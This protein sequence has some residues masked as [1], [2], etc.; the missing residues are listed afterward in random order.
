M[1]FIFVILLVSGLAL[2][3][4]QGL[5]NPQL[6][7]VVAGD[8]TLRE[9][10]TTLT[11]TQTTDR[12]ILN[13]NSFD[14]GAGEKTDFVQLDSDS[15]VL[16]R[17]L[18]PG[19]STI[20]GELTAVGRVF[21]VNPE[22]VVFTSDAN[23][24]L[25]G[26]LVSAADI[27]DQ[28]FLDDRL[29]F[30]QPGMPGSMITNHGDISTQGNAVLLADRIVNHGLIQARL[31]SVS[32]G[33]VATATI[34]FA[35]DGLLSL[36]TQ[37]TSALVKNESDGR[38]EALGGNVYISALAED[39]ILDE[40][41]NLDGV[42]QATHAA[43]EGGTI[44][45]YGGTRGTVLVSGEV[46]ATGE[47][48]TVS[49]D[50]QRIGLLAGGSVKAPGGQ[51]EVGLGTPASAD[52]SERIFLAS[53]AALDVAPAD[54]GEDA[55]TV[56]LQAT[57]GAQLQGSV[58]ANGRA[59]GSGG[60]LDLSAGQFELSGDV[61]V[62][63]AT[64]G[65]LILRGSQVLVANSAIAA[66]PMFADIPTSVV[67][68]AQ[69]SGLNSSVTLDGTGSLVL[70][71]GVN[72]DFVNL[73]GS[74][75]VVLRGAQM[76]L[77]PGFAVRTYG[78]ALTLEAYG[79]ADPN[80]WGELD[81]V[82]SGSIITGG[83][84]VV[85]ESDILQPALSDFDVGGGAVT[86]RGTEVNIAQIGE[87]DALAGVVTIT[88]VVSANIERVFA[89]EL[90]IS[91]GVSATVGG[92][93]PRVVGVALFAAP[94]Q[95][96]PALLGKLNVQAPDVDLLLGVF[97][98]S[99]S[100][101]I[102]ADAL[103]MAPGIRFSGGDLSIE[104][105]R[106]AP[107]LIVLTQGTGVVAPES[108]LLEPFS[109]LVISS[110]ILQIENRFRSITIGRDNGADNIF[111]SN[112]DLT[113]SVALDVPLT[114]KA[115]NGLIGI[116]G[117]VL[118]ESALTTQGKV[119]LSGSIVTQG[120]PL[121]FDDV[122]RVSDDLVIDTTFGA[123]IGGAD[124]TFTD[125]VV[126][127]DATTAPN[128]TIFGTTQTNVRIDDIT[129]FADLTI[130]GVGT[131]DI[132]GSVTAQILNL[133]IADRF[134][135]DGALNLSGGLINGAG[136]TIALQSGGNLGFINLNAAPLELGGDLTVFG[137]F[138]ANDL[139]LTSPATIT[140]IPGPAGGAAISIAGTVTSQGNALTL[141]T[142]GVGSIDA[143]SLTNDFAQLNFNA[144]G[145]TIGAAAADGFTGV[146]SGA[147]D[148]AVGGDLFASLDVAGTTTL[149]STGRVLL[150]GTGNSFADTISIQAA[151]GV[152]LTAPTLLL[153]AS[154]FGAGD[155]DIVTGGLEILGPLS[156]SGQ[157]SFRPSDPTQTV[158]LG[159]ESGLTGFGL[160]DAEMANISD[161]FAGITFIGPSLITVTDATFRDPVTFQEG[162]PA[163]QLQIVGDLVGLDDASFTI[164]GT[165]QT[166]FLAGNIFTQGRPIVFNDSVVLLS[167]VLLDT[168]AGPG[169]AAGD[170]TMNLGLQG[171]GFAL[172][173]A[174][175]RWVNNPNFPLDVGR[176]NVDSTAASNSSALV[177]GVVAGAGA[178]GAAPLVSLSGFAPDAGFLIN[179]CAMA[180][181]C[182]GGYIRGLVNLPPPVIQISR[183]TQEATTVLRDGASRLVD[184]LDTRHSNFG[185]ERLWWEQPERFLATEEER[186]D[187]D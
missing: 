59:D 31:G 45:L 99:E 187:E 140:T 41:V 49:I 104:P 79:T 108:F 53:G 172:S 92:Q 181:A 130:E 183:A 15:V 133:D 67:T 153:G 39:A 141:E 114:L 17:V 56:S 44:R 90:N 40:V 164:N 32:L 18:G 100:I 136:A 46:A 6:D 150:G 27:D 125:L 144:A 16:N 13:W 9:S 38:I 126:D 63:G 143:P 118:S 73:P 185:N 147:L 26:L 77:E 61:D 146:V 131:V 57:A 121:V 186:P 37:T 33:G 95:F 171:G 156:G 14:I 43:E 180:I 93:V 105:Y 154:D 70:E 80:D 112:G 103:D 74:G 10:G 54:G 72:L 119:L 161:G 35:G 109:P 48:V 68:G 36:A 24:N 134:A 137:D 124:V 81:F 158:E 148:L 69:L 98:V 28:D 122:V 82:E 7:S 58:S 149:S 178:R 87:P 78:S 182:E 138:T 22:G 94:G 11:V 66:L 86:A 169:L 84:D 174:A 19:I 167:D 117:L 88:G 135:V 132:A 113:E 163:S 168:R 162:S 62:G 116:D 1:R 8:V 166:T 12:A 42:V 96:Y 155:V 76:R 102:K 51:V 89:Q 160:S 71:S 91:A 139:L 123:N 142:G 145:V 115:P 97:D 55:G 83:G 165:G 64:P 2:P 176:L 3:S 110:D 128:I 52:I 5:A 170:V 50:G 75:K 175:G 23:V 107:T 20:A 29:V 65:H 25:S 47:D 111:L 152:E 179:G 60:T 120:T 101:S 159:F 85:F 127:P 157:I 173:I 184:P 177:Y 34:D 4:G 21:I 106:A 151:D 129:G 30:D